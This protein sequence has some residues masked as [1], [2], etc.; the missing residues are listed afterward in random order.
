MLDWLKKRRRKRITRQPWPESWTDVLQQNVRQYRTI[1]ESLKSRWQ[2]VT[3]VIV[4]E[5]YWE[6]CAGLAINDE[7][8]V[9]IAA[10]AG[11]MLL[12][13]N[14]FFF[15]NVR[16]VLVYPENQ[17]TTMRD[18][19]MVEEG[20]PL[21]GQAWQGGPVILSWADVLSG[22][23]YDDGHNLVVHEFA[24]CLDGL[25]GEMGGSPVFDNADSAQRWQS[26]IT[27]E[28]KRLTRAVERGER[29]LLDPYGATNH[30]EFF[31]VASETFFEQPV[32]MQQA[33]PELFGLMVEYF[34]IN[35]AN[36]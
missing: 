25:D 19:L 10:Q 34:H 18:G 26:V 36:W 14:D 8:K 6:G 16:T 22:A 30:A 9:T 17:T 21:A 33:M 28:F 7:I 23:H 20:T 3:K 15:D 27:Q 32:R 11:M 35:P 2:D 13:V 12:G 31:A 4:A 24:H 1:N 5:K 29:T